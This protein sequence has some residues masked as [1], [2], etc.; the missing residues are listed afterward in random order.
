[1]AGK[2]ANCV[3]KTLAISFLLPFVGRWFAQR[4]PSTRSSLTL[5]SCRSWR[6]LGGNSSPFRETAA[7]RKK[8]AKATLDS[9]SLDN[10]DG[11]RKKQWRNF[12]QLKKNRK[13]NTKLHR[14]TKA[15]HRQLLYRAR[16][17]AGASSIWNA[18]RAV[19]KT[20][21]INMKGILPKSR[22]HNRGNQKDTRTRAHNYLQRLETEL[23]SFLC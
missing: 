22:R 18:A 21:R 15:G 8:E 14:G 2:A 9:R 11:K 16:A 13:Q 1:M 12:Q 10:K 5:G 23:L 20:D 7:A 17:G 6:P 4:L 3:Q 19:C